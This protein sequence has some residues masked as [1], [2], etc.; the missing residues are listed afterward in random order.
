[1]VNSLVTE[2]A[3]DHMGIVFHLHSIASFS[4][5]HLVPSQSSIGNLFFQS[6]QQ[7]MDHIRPEIFTNTDSFSNL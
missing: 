7:C 4:V 6:H 2:T 5:Y 3:D 1:M